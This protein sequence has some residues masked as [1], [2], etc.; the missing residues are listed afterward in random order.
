MFCVCA[1]WMKWVINSFIDTKHVTLTQETS[2]LLV[3]YEKNLDLK[4]VTAIGFVQ[5]HDA[6]SRQGRDKGRWNWKTLGK[7]FGGVVRLGGGGEPFPPA[8]VSRGDLNKKSFFIQ[9]GGA[10]C[11]NDTLWCSHEAWSSGFCLPLT[12]KL[13]RRPGDRMKGEREGRVEIEELWHG[14]EICRDF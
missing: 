5:V 3:A 10:A 8:G 7:S 12:A 9:Q 14:R 6:M 2:L 11:Y 13:A 4:V 1:M